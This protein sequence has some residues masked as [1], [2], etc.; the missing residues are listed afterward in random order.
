MNL[1]SKTL[2]LAM[3]STL[4]AS[5][6]AMP[7]TVLAGTSASYAVSNMYLWRGQN[8]AVGGAV[9]GSLDY[10][11]D[12]GFYAGVW[13]SSEG[14][15]ATTETDLYFGFAGEA[16]KF[17]YD[18]SY[19]NYLY[20][21]ALDAP[22][23]A[24]VGDPVTGRTDLLDSNAEEIVIGLGFADFSFAAYINVDSDNSDDNYFTF[25]YTYEKFDVTIGLWDRDG[26]ADEYTHVTFGYAA[27]DNLSFALSFAQS[28][29]GTTEEDPLFAVTY[30][31]SFDL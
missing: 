31:Q 27:T 13:G 8:V 10:S 4:V 23:P 5:A 11:H 20:P 6:F 26:T 25:G 3:A 18:I 28:D 12:N 16:G 21:E 1:K 9:S 7:T 29:D 14:S 19:W 2:Q 24:G 15:Y 22:P 17:N 30:G